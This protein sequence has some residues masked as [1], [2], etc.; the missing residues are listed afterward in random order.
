MAPVN[1][2]GLCKV[3]VGQLGRFLWARTCTSFA[4]CRQLASEANWGRCF[5]LQGLLW[6][7]LPCEVDRTCERLTLFP[8]SKKHLAL[9]S[10]GFCLGET[11]G[12]VNRRWVEGWGREDPSLSLLHVSSLLHRGEAEYSLLNAGRGFFN[13]SKSCC[14]GGPAW[15]VASLN[16]LLSSWCLLVRAHRT[17]CILKFSLPIY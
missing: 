7:H 1:S 10:E 17:H 11:N 8:L 14:V 13:G 12:T 9:L 5:A 6:S 2:Q 4:F 15:P 16:E 3:S